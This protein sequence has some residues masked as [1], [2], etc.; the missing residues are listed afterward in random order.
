MGKPHEQLEAWKFAMQSAKAVY[1]LTVGF[2]VQERY[3]LAQGQA[4]R[5]VDSIKVRTCREIGQ[6]IV[7]FEQ[8]GADR[9]AYGVPLIPR[10]AKSP[11]GEFGRGVMP[12]ICA[13]CD[14]FTWRFR[15]V[16]RCVTN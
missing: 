4:L 3:G 8:L 7:E 6:H 1:D 9:A 13:T 12:P 10:L 2:P 14:F 11:T 5:A 16:T 15:F